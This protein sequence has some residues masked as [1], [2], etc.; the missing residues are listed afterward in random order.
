MD[1]GATIL[2]PTRKRPV[3][4]SPDPRNHPIRCT[5]DRKAEKDGGPDIQPIGSPRHFALLPP[6]LGLPP[7][8]TPGNSPAR[9]DWREATWAIIP[10]T[11]RKA[12]AWFA[13]P[14]APGA[15]LARPEL[16]WF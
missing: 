10:L 9:N 5:Q 8:R 2:Q 7:A 3:V 14:P 4:S 12:D 13:T 11:R 6:N 16:P 15:P 1:R